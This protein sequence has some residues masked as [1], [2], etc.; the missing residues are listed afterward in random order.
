MNEKKE[1]PILM[2]AFSVKAILD[3]RKTQTRRVIRPQPAEWYWIDG[4][5]TLNWKGKIYNP[6]QGDPRKQLLIDCRRL[7][8]GDR[9]WVRETFTWIT[10]AENEWRGTSDQRRHPDGYP[11]TML[12]RADAEAEGWLLPASWKPS[13][14]MPRWASRILLEITDVRVERVQEISDIDILAEGIHWRDVIGHSP[15]TVEDS[16]AYCR[17]F[18]ELWDS[19]NTKRGFG[20]DV[21]PWVRAITFKCVPDG[22]EEAHS[23]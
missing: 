9:L 6:Y 14:F 5:V 3:G 4:A 13:I 18:R 2:N 10:L 12:N 22:T 7:E 8:I 19:I 21:N 16:M 23:A 15:R 20:W 1:R 17:A 11:V